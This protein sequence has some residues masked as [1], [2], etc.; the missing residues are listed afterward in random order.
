MT[1]INL[2]KVFVKVDVTWSLIGR[3]TNKEQRH[4]EGVAAAL[5][6]KG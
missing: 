6:K 4:P 2:Y 1:S 3:F 5:V